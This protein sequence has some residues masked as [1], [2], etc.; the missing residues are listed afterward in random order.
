MKRFLEGLLKKHRFEEMRLPSCHRD[1]LCTGEPVSFRDTGD[2]FLPIR[3]SCSYPGL[4][5]PV[6]A[7]IAA[8][9]RRD[10]H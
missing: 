7:A 1:H 8:R 2:V 4:F 3:A 6:P 5:R 9:G 10:E